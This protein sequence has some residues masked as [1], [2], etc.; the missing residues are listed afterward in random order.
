MI[1]YHSTITSLTKSRVLRAIFYGEEFEIEVL[2]AQS[3][4]IYVWNVKKID[5]WQAA[6]LLESADIQ[7][8]YGFGDYKIEARRNAEHVLEKWKGIG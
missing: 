7:L 4:I 5:I 3:M 1:L 6:V 2:D 8:G